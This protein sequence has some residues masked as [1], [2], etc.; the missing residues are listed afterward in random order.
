MFVVFDIGTSRLKVSAFSA[1]GQLLGQVTKRHSHYVEKEFS[2]QDTR[3]WWSNACTGF[4]KLMQEN[5]LDQKAIRGFSVCG[6]AGAGVFVDKKGEVIAEPWSDARH[7]PLLGGLREQ[8]PAAPTYGLALISK[9]QWLKQNQPEICDDIRH[10][11]YAKDFLLYK[12]TAIGMTDPSSGP[13]GLAWFDQACADPELL[14]TP[15]LPW[16]IAG[17]LTNAAAGELGCPSGIPVAVG[18]H[19]GICANTGCAMINEADYALTLGT[20]A[21]CRTMT[22]T[23]HG[24][25]ERFYC[26]PPD[27]HAYGGNNWHIGSTLTWM[28]TTLADLPAELSAGELGSFNEAMVS[29]KPDPDLLFLPYLGGQTIPEKRA[30]GSGSFQGLSLNTDCNQMLLAVFRGCAFSVFRTYQALSGIAGDAERIGLTGGGIVFTSWL[31]L[32]SNLF[33]K[34]MILTDSGVEGRGAAIFCAVALGD[35]RD[36]FEAAPAMQ[37]ESTTIQPE[38]L[39]E[40]CAEQFEIFSRLSSQT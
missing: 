5:A 12:L 3:E 4:A 38:T 21:V 35:F 39:D 31:Q 33:Q 34:E 28:L 20:H 8:Y 26:F 1:T 27:R 10:C 2:W 22:V 14:P 40:L 11:L 23:N 15:A 30:L 17:E 7:R 32:L 24:A 37:P 18:A 9:Y 16:T 13:D 25:A 6:R 29:T 19:D 36:V